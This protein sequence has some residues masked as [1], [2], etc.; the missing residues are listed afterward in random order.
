[1]EET[2]ERLSRLEPVQRDAVR[3]VLT[4]LVDQRGMSQAADVL[5][6]W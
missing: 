2:R 1:M 3:A 4:Y 6:D 5:R